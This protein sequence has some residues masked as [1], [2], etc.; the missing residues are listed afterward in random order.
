MPRNSRR[1]C[2]DSS[3]VP[4]HSTTVACSSG[5]RPG[6]APSRP[7]G[8]RTQGAHDRH[9]Q[10]EVRSRACRNSI[11]RYD[12]LGQSGLFQA[13]RDGARQELQPGVAAQ[14]QRQDRDQ[15]SGHDRLLLHLSSR[16]DRIAERRKM[17][18]AQDRGCLESRCEAPFWQFAQ[19]SPGALAPP[20]AFTAQ[21]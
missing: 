19:A 11:R 21:R 18:G 20:T 1:T 13:H 2:G 6:F 8:S 10:D 7:G 16:D 4:S 17:N 12:P 3:K 14:N 5:C 9:R 15:A